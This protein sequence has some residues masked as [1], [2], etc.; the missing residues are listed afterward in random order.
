M[1]NYQKIYENIQAQ[2]KDQT[3]LPIS[4]RD[5]DYSMRRFVE[6]VV[7]AA[8]EESRESIHNNSQLLEDLAGMAADIRYQ[9]SELEDAVESLLYG[10][11]ETTKGG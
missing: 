1:I 3:G 8:V 9:S 6:G 10:D 4:Y 11:A 5:L 7:D 2:C